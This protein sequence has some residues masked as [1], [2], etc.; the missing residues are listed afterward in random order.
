MLLIVWG[1]G[2]EGKEDV[3]LTV[4]GRNSAKHKTL[5]FIHDE[6]LFYFFDTAIENVANEHYLIEETVL[7][8]QLNGSAWTTAE[9]FKN[10]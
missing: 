2:V 5:W 4:N 9:D 7:W 3:I 1:Q 6:Q 10:A 8:K